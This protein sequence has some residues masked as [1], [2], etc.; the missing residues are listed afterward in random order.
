M[1]LLSRLHSQ[2]S[3][4]RLSLILYRLSQPDAPGMSFNGIDGDWFWEM[5][6]KYYKASSSFFPS[7]WW[8]DILYELNGRD[9]CAF[10]LVTNKGNVMPTKQAT[11][12]EDRATY[13]S[14][15]PDG[16]PRGMLIRE[17]C[18]P[19]HVKY[20]V[21]VYNGFMHISILM[22]K[23]IQRLLLSLQFQGFDVGPA[24]L[25]RCDHWTTFLSWDRGLWRKYSQVLTWQ[26]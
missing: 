25:I 2:R 6:V 22:W 19:K 5:I 10:P 11:V 21:K 15:V 9:T 7:L 17:A 4:P 20:D 18:L 23:Y 3:A 8:D 13:L 1:F 26:S 24:L 16:P 12:L 14:Q